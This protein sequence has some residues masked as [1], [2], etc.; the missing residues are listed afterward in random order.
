MAYD[1]IIRLQKDATE[2]EGICEWILVEK[3]HKHIIRTGEDWPVETDEVFKDVQD[4]IVI[5]PMVE[6]FLTEVTMPRLSSDRL[7]KAIPYALEDKLTE[8]PSSLDFIIGE[9]EKKG[10]IPVAIVHQERMQTWQTLL[11]NRLPANWHA[12]INVMLPAALV[13]PWQPG[14]W[15]ILLDHD[16][17]IVR[18]GKQAGFAIEKELLMQSLQH[19]LIIQRPTAIQLYCTIDPQVFIEE[20]TKLAVPLHVNRIANPLATMAETIK[21]PYPLNLIENVYSNKQRRTNVE[22]ALWICSAIAGLWLLVSTVTN[23]TSYF[24]LSGE[25]RALNEQEG[26]VYS[27]L[28]PNQPVPKNAKYS[29]QRELDQL[30]T[31][32]AENT[33]L[34]LITIISPEMVALTKSGLTINKMSYKNNQ[35][36]F[37]VAFKNSGL[38]E[39]LVRSLEL[40]GISAV[41]S[42]TSL[43][44]EGVIG[45]HLT[46]NEGS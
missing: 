7:K 5:V 31:D 6:I 25:K 23:I 4:I 44:T 43:S 27:A 3:S 37:D 9:E 16:M 22:I 26:K 10:V 40:Q 33:F 28:Y 21:K 29:V 15:S 19:V 12:H 39:N 17:A 35:I 38:L 34:R 45:A 11:R 46:I 18:I 24:I 1:L 42:N 14:E 30:Q 13:T 41:V 32:N 36:E 8:D 2:E 20:L